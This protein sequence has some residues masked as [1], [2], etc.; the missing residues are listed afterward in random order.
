MQPLAAILVAALVTTACFPEPPAVDRDDV[1]GEVDG[2][3]AEL[4]VD[5]PIDTAPETTLDTSPETTLD[6]SPE[7][8]VDTS[9]E[10]MVD[11]SPETMVDTSPETMVDTTP[12]TALDTTSETALDTAP[13]TALD[14]APETALDTGPIDTIDD[15]ADVDP[16][17]PAGSV[18]AARNLSTQAVC[19]PQGTRIVAT[20]VAIVEAVVTT[21]RF[22]AS[23]AADG[24]VDGYFVADQDGGDFSGIVLRILPAQRPARE[25]EP[26]D[27]VT[28]SGVLQQFF[29]WTQLEVATLALD[30]PVTPPVPLLLAPTELS[31]R[32]HESR[33]VR[34]EHTQVVEAS[35]AGGWKLTPGDVTL[36]FAFPGFVAFSPGQ[37]CDFTGVM[38]YF[39]N[40]YQLVP[41][42]PMDIVFDDLVPA[43]LRG[44]QSS[45]V[46]ASCPNADTMLVHGEHSLQIQGTVVV[47]RHFISSELDGYFVSDGSGSAWS[48]S[49]VTIR[50]VP[51]ATSFAVG[52]EVVIIGNHQ[53]FYCNTQIAAHVI[54]RIGGAAPVPAPLIIAKNPSAADLE[55]YEGVLV[56]LHDVVV[57]AYSST[58]RGVATDAGV[59][60][61]NG[62]MPAEDFAFGAAIVGRT[63]SVLRGVV[64]FSR[65]SYRVSPRVASDMQLAP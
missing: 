55:S 56:E 37:T 64:R 20:G 50:S 9:P 63:L 58:A 65:A 36:G 59:L 32:E 34:V 2:V 43:T 29:C 15:V 39:Y 45:A 19:D 27:V 24:S 11:T 18:K 12:E 30:A 28:V 52:D 61:D 7:T 62:I 31:R 23:A 38:R 44:I 35:A 57:G 53:E 54:T 41:R 40:A 60:I 47:G 22:D 48:A 33:L 26:G 42:G 14:T 13:E 46:S 21:R 25:L 10:T 1:D 5:A 3:D 49:L 17:P 51:E 8:T 6:T 4:G 16:G